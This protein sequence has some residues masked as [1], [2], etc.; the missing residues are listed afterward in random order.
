MTSLSRTP[1]RLGELVELDLVGVLLRRVRPRMAHQRLQRD[2]VTA[3]LA[4]EAIGEAVPQLMRGEAPHACAPADAPDHP[5]ES[6]I[7]RRPLRILPTP[8]TIVRRY[9]LLGF[10][11]EDVIVEFRLELAEAGAQLVDDVGIEWQPVPVLAF[12]MHADAPADEVEV[13]PTTASDFGSPEACPLHEHERR[14]L[15]G[16]SGGSKS[17]ELIEARPIDVGLSLR[18]PSDLPRRVELD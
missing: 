14:P 7:A 1:Q 10:Y 2:E 13:R 3:A 6:L 4:Q 5:H 15:V 18:R 12:A 17:R 11:R 8:L 16:K 9:P